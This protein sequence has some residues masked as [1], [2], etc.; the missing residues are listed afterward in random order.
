MKKKALPALALA[1]ALCLACQSAL[2]AVS[3]KVLSRAIEIIGQMESGHNYATVIVDSNGKISAGFM[4]WNAGRAAALVEKA[5]QASGEDID[6]DGTLSASDKEWVSQ[7]LSS[8]AGREVQDAQARS[9]VTGYIEKAM[10]LGIQ[11]PNALCYYADIVHQVGTGAIKKYHV[12]A[13]EKAG[14]YENVTLEHLYQAALNYATYTKARRTKVYN[15]LKA[16]PISGSGGQQDQENQESQQAQKPTALR[17]SPHEAQTL[18]IGQTLTLSVDFQP[19]GSSQAVKWSSSNKKV[20][21]VKDGVVTAVKA[22]KAYIRV[23]SESGLSHRIAVT[24]KAPA[25][26]SLS[27]SGEAAMK[28][29]KSQTLALTLSPQGSTAKVKWKSS[30]KKV[31]KV[32][33]KGRVT[34]LKAGTAVIQC[35]TASGLKARFTITVTK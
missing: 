26:E 9:D 29:G 10:S 11:D 3:E 7:L 34:A 14:G 28:K 33:Q 12:L 17:I 20:A 32:N 8:P 2:A 1:L 4:Q 5:I 31:V 13:A 27:L 30:N 15:L 16:D 23:Q 6:F 21:I 18:T 19:A 25:V 22:G 35:Q 24:V